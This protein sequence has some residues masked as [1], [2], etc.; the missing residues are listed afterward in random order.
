MEIAQQLGSAAHIFMRDGFFFLFDVGFQGANF[1]GGDVSDKLTRHLNFQHAPDGKD[2]LG[3]V[4]GGRRN[5]SA[6]GGLH[7]NELILGKL[8]KGLP[9]Q[10]SGDT[11]VGGQL[12]LGQFGARHEPVIHY[13]FG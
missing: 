5:K 4:G 9:D 6:T 10:C 2:L 11:K 13:G 1:G 3:F 7:A 8:K 12:L